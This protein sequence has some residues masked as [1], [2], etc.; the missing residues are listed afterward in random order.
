MR[1]IR[2]ICQLFRT[3]PTPVEV[4]EHEEIEESPAQATAT[5]NDTDSISTISS[6][7]FAITSTPPQHTMRQ[8]FADSKNQVDSNVTETSLETATSNDFPCSPP[9]QF[10]IGEEAARKLGCAPCVIDIP[11]LTEAQGEIVSF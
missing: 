3:A 1:F 11:Y 2:F 9:R 8:A 4:I 6:P 5:N 10:L 7:S